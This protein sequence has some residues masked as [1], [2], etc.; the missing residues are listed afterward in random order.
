[1]AAPS[2]VVGPGTSTGGGLRRLQAAVQRTTPRRC[3]QVQPGGST[4]PCVQNGTVVLPLP[5]PVLT[6]DGHLPRPS[7]TSVPGGG[8]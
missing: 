6:R 2:E 5:L 8:G 4:G 7:R 1:M 3:A